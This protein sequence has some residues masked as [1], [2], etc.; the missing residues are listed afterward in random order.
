MNSL[1]LTWLLLA[2]N[3]MAGLM[4]ITVSMDEIEPV[5]QLPSGRKL[6]I[7][8]PHIPEYQSDSS[9]MYTAI[10]DHPLFTEGR[11]PEIPEE[12]E[13]EALEE[14]TQ[15]SNASEFKLV[16]IVVSPENT[17][18][19]LLKPDRTVERVN[20]GN[21]IDGWELESVDMA[22][23]VLV[24]GEKN[25][26]LELDRTTTNVPKVKARAKRR[27]PVRARNDDRNR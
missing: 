24:K 6:N 4:L 2:L 17:Q 25:I 12:Q 11:L 26:Q 23:V 21:K 19:L 27:I 7:E 20:L 3:L 16:G 1:R 9:L 15:N 13:T 22:A 14:E 5:E 18:A 8:M 10:I